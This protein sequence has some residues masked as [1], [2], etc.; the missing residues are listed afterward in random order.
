MYPKKEWPLLVSGQ[1]LRGTRHHMVS[2][3]FDGVIAIFATLRL[4]EAGVIYIETPVKALEWAIPGI[5]QERSYECCRAIPMAMQQIWK[6]RN[7]VCQRN[8][9]FTGTMHLRISSGQDGRLRGHREWRLRVSLSKD[10]AFACD[11]VKLRGQATARPQKTH[12]VGPS[13][14][15]GD[16][17]DVGFALSQTAGRK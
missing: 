14:I 15:E 13:G 7:S 6:V 2:I 3:A 5:Q 10:H 16:E 1:P 4:V 9:Q 12:P 17:N 11:S 8:S